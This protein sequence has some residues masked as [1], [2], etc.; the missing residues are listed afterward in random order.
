MN[1]VIFVTLVVLSTLILIELIVGIYFAKTRNKYRRI[2]SNEKIREQFSKTRKELFD[3]VASGELDPKSYTFKT[4]YKIHTFILRSPDK[5]E[6]LGNLLADAIVVDSPEETEANQLKEESK[7]W[8][9]R[10]KK[11]VVSTGKGFAMIVNEFAPIF[12]FLPRMR[13]KLL[14]FMLDFPLPEQGKS[15]KKIIEAENTMLDLA[16]IN[17]A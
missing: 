16:A 13:A 10:T 1:N 11:L 14:I 4:F 12:K 17:P 5:Y 8:G 3:L 9:K 6:E 7:Y 15:V 2:I